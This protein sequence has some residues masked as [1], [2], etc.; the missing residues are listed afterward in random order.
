MVSKL[1][2]L[3]INLV[4]FE[5][6]V[7]LFKQEKEFLAEVYHWNTD[8]SFALKKQLARHRR[9]Y[10]SIAQIDD[11]P[12]GHMLWFK[13]ENTLTLTGYFFRHLDDPSFELTFLKRLCKQI[14]NEFENFSE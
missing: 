11:E 7:T 4:P 1:K 6:V 13:E 10:G 12:V 2:D 8:Y 3:D 5:K 9:L 14:R